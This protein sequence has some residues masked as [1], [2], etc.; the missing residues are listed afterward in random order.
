MQI[1]DALFVEAVV[2]ANVQVRGR[3]INERN[4]ITTC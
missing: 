2:I 3:G 1:A 4:A